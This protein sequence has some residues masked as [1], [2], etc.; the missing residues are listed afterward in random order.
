MELGQYQPLNNDE[1]LSIFKDY[2][3][4]LQINPIDYFAIGIQ[5]LITKSST[6]LMSN[7]DWQKTFCQLNLAKHDPLRLASFK[8]PS[9][10]FSFED[11]QPSSSEG[12]E[13][14]R[15]R[16]RYGMNSGVVLTKKTAQHKLLL[17]MA[18]GFKNFKA[19]RFIAD[20]H[21]ALRRVFADLTQLIEPA[22]N[23][24]ISD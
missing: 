21:V 12:K 19:Y 8:T 22:L 18:T 17:T 4:S 9:N 3:D 20:N 23:G 14:M 6:S 24:T 1:L 5:N 13:V 15:Q 7:K 10:T 16:K 2:V 11:L